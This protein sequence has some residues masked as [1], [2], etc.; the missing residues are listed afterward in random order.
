MF[1]D[2]MR[3]HDFLDYWARRTPDAEFAVLGSRRLTY[4]QAQAESFRLANAFLASGLAAGDRV[5]VLSKNSIEYVILYYAAARVGVV[6][7]PLNYRLAPAEWAWIVADARAR[8]LLVSVDF[9][10]AVDGVRD[11]LDAVERFVAI[12]APPSDGWQPYREWVEAQSATPPA[13]HVSEEQ[14]LYQ[15]YTSGTTGRPKGALLTHRAIGANLAQF[16]IAMEATF[17]E[18][19]LLVVP[20]YHASGAV[21]SFAAIQG[22]GSLY[23]QQDFNP[24]AVVRALSEE[25][26]GRTSLV[27]AMIQACLVTVPDVAA[28]RYER[29]RLIAYGASPIAE[30]TLRRALAVFGCDFVQA[31]G[32][33]ETSA[34]LTYLLPADHRRALTEKPDLLLSAGRPVVGVDL[35]IVD[36]NDV[37]V[38]TGTIGEIVARG[39]QLMQGYWNRPDETR[40]ALRGGFMHT[41]DAG[42]VDEEGFVYIQDRVKDMIVSGGENIYPRM[43][44]EVLF[45]HPAIADAA[46]I[47]VPHETWGETVKAVVVLRTGARATEEEIV[48]F[49]RGKLGGFQRPRSVDLVAELPRNPTGKVLRRVLREP[50][51]AGHRRRVA[52]S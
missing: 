13:C 25:G 26:I 29:L 15:M 27:P 14:V 18:R 40:E 50:Y 35:R 24:H 39:P 34:V 4:V 37:A 38:P 11:A 1:S 10:A 20:M 47:G 49:C 17:G 41:G 23:L 7:V 31:Y 45:T 36:E 3:L 52:G 33:T 43:I 6:P 28:R 48:D 30:A 12:D 32:M 44:E 2:V 9:R 19:W 21:T 22:G 5:A 42:V 51:W 8:L 46:A 16:M